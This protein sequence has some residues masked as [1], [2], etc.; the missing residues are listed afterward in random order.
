[1]AGETLVFSAHGQTAVRVRALPDGRVSVVNLGAGHTT[2]VESLEVAVARAQRII[3]M[4]TAGDAQR[5]AMRQR[6]TP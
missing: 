5:A 1:M 6:R 4:L 3:R 2:Y